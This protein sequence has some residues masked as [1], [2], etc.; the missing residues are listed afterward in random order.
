MLLGMKKN[1]P[2]TMITVICMRDDKEKMLSLLFKHTS[3][4][5]IRET[6]HNRYV[7]DRKINTVN[8]VFG[9]VRIKESSGYGVKKYKPE[10][11][12]VA[13]IAEENEMGIREVQTVLSKEIGDLYE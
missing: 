7:L 11:E 1:R 4:L 2:G 8:T 12:D 3:T 13:R 5:G 6:T 9:P 10:Y